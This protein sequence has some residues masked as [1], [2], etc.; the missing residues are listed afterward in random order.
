MD[1]ED[2]ILESTIDHIKESKRTLIALPKFL[3]PE[4]ASAGIAL[5]DYLTKIGKEV[6]LASSGN[7]PMAL[8]FLG[9]K[10][11]HDIS[12]LVKNKLVITVNTEIVKL[13]EI[14]YE[15]TSDKAVIYLT[16]KTGDFT[17]AD[18]SITKKSEKFDLIIA[19]GATTLEDLG[20]LYANNAELFYDTP[21]INIDVAA[22]NEYF[23]A[24]NLVDVTAI[25][26]SEVV[27]N[28]LEKI[29]ATQ[30][31]EHAATALLAGIIAK[32]HSFQDVRTTP[33]A[34]IV[35]ARL[36]DLGGNHQEAVQYIYKTKPLPLL[37][38]WGRALARLRSGEVP[39]VLFSTLTKADLE[40]TDFQN[41][42]VEPPAVL[43]ELLDNVSGFK[44]VSL[45][46]EFEDKID[47]Y[48]AVHPQIV[49]EG[50]FESLGNSGS[51]STSFNFYTLV[52]F[53]WNMPLEDAEIKLSTAFK[54]VFHT[55]EPI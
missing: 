47:V 42:N 14:S 51:I 24:L 6:V 19:I 32:T 17:E 15:T 55:A 10:L 43:R 50:L 38:V 45:L 44:I 25:S 3:T 33:K 20:D 35:A 8:S 52:T 23:G 54:E 1:I 48:L 9:G 28:L 46:L 31:S 27:F 53:T 13:G 18:V 12:S 37:Q 11:T 21:V 16:P 5:Q 22:T 7:I 34:F 26:I 39:G 40:K 49:L 30:I 4:S 36:M 41:A 29:D 2:K